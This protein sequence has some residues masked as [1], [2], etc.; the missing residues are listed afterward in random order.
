[1]KHSES[2]D[3]IAPALCKAQES[4]QLHKKTPPQEVHL[5]F[6]GLVNA[7]RQTIL[8]LCTTDLYFFYA[9]LPAF[10]LLRS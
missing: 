9:G 2:L 3:K 4:L 6:W 1:M 8:R 10:G 5:S 7:V